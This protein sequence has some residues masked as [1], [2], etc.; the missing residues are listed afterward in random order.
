MLFVCLLWTKF[1]DAVQTLDFSTPSPPSPTP[2]PFPVHKRAQRNNAGRQCVICN[3]AISKASLQS[4]V[5]KRYADLDGWQIEDGVEGAMNLIRASTLVPDGAIEAYPLGHCVSNFVVVHMSDVKL[6]CERVGS[7]RRK[8]QAKL[9][10][11]GTCTVNQL[12][13]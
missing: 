1:G 12:A 6:F 3:P 7:I 10:L 11:V 8:H 13:Y 9:G 4:S 5:V 2:Q